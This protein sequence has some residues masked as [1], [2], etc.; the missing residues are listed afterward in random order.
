MSAKQKGTEWFS[1]P[2]E[3]RRRKSI[4]LTLS[5]E[6]RERLDKMAR[7][8]KASRSAVVDELVMEA[9]IRSTKPVAP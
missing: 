6:A 9:P 2:E 5:E 8:R 1:T 7:A 4:E 3:R